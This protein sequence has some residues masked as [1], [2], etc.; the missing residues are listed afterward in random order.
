MKNKNLGFTLI[1]LVIVIVILGVLAAIAA[2]KFIDVNSE[3]KE[4]TIKA[5]GGAMH[6]AAQLV[7]AKAVLQ[8]KE[9]QPLANVDI[10]GDGVDDVETKYG[11]PS[12]SRANGLSV[13]MAGD[14]AQDWTW[15][16]TF[17]ETLFY[18]STSAIAG[19]TGQ[20]VNQVPF[21]NTNCY[22]TYAAATAVGDLPTIAYELSGC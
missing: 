18:A 14:F 10:D 4:A 1:E 13:V 3:A 7:Y 21:L 20:Y 19:P 5:M 2:P 11:Y 9:K 16:T 6:S 22:V 15:S 8:N 12:A 17:T